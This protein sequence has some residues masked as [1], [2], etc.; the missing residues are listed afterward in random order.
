MSSPLEAYDIHCS[1]HPDTIAVMS[2]QEKEVSLQFFLS[3]FISGQES[4]YKRIVEKVTGF[5]RSN[6]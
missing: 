1:K 6:G 5:I 4:L 2:A 3:G